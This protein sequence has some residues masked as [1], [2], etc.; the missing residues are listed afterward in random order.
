MIVKF[1][2]ISFSCQYDKPADEIVKDYTQEFIARNLQNLSIKSNFLQD[3]HAYHA[4][5][6]YQCK[7]KYPIEITAYPRCSGENKKYKV[8]D[9]EIIVFSKNVVLTTAFFEVVGFNRMEGGKLELLPI[10]EQKKVVLQVKEADTGAVYLDKAGFGSLAFV[11]DRVE[12]HKKQ[13]ENSGYL[14]T[15]I[16]SLTVNEKELKICFAAND[17]GDIV[18]FIGIR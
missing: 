2:H 13:L 10:M 15:D 4:I 18:E 1:D 11:V 7:G 5:S 16:E 3:N 8:M 9:N 17:A 12:K 6:L 14:V